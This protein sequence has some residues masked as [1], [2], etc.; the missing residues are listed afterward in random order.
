MCLRQWSIAPA[1]AATLLVFSM[2]A[3]SSGA[4]DADGMSSPTTCVELI[5]LDDTHVDLT[6]RETS[7]LKQRCDAE[8]IRTKFAALDQDSD[9]YLAASHMLSKV[10]AE[11]DFDGDNRLSLA[12][13]A[14]HD[15]ETDPIE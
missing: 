12:E 11:V 6:N 5:A 4:Q 14:E 13:V 1:V 7:A 15:A 10:F 3:R 9:D 2:Q 8:D